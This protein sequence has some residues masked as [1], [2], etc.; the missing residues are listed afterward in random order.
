MFCKSMILVCVFMYLVAILANEAKRVYVCCFIKKEIRLLVLFSFLQFFFLIW[1]D[2]KLLLQS[3]DCFIKYVPS[4]GVIF[5]FFRLGR[6]CC[7]FAD[8]YCY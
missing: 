7:Q 5:E 1:H 2:L 4:M 8:M 6:F 3:I